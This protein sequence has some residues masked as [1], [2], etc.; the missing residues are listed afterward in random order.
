MSEKNF[1]FVNEINEQKK[2]DFLIEDDSQ[3]EQPKK[4]IS[5]EELAKKRKK[6][7]IKR[8]TITGIVLLILSG[9]VFGFALFWQDHYDLLAICNAL[10][11]AF[12]VNLFI[13]WIMFVYNKN[14]LSPMI[15]GFK[16]FGLMFVGKRPKED[17]Y[18]Y[19]VRISENQI[20]KYLYIS[21][22]I[23]AFIILIPAIITMLILM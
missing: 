16:V 6:E 21:T 23:A 14:I 17:Y 22:F 19:T 5:Q 10:W 18:E 13:G 4:V 1:K 7:L 12:G 3:E 9:T 20:P 8:Y 2:D 11:F 15:H